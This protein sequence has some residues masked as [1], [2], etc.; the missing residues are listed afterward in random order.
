[1]VWMNYFVIA[2]FVESEGLRLSIAI[3]LVL[4]SLQEAHLW[5]PLSK[6]SKIC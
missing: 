6:Q 4:G 1:M 3:L 5:N 2:G